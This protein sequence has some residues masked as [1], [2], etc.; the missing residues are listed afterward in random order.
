MPS[1]YG[2]SV[3]VSVHVLGHVPEYTDAFIRVINA[4]VTK[5]QAG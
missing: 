4:A 3:I 2:A 5:G 1:G